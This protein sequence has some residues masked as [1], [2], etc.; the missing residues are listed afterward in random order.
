MVKA[1]QQRQGHRL[2]HRTQE[3]NELAV[4]QP[5]PV[6]DP[7]RFVRHAVAGRRHFAVCDSVM[8]MA[9]ETNEG[10]PQVPG[11]PCQE[12]RHRPP[13]SVC[14][15][16]RD[17]SLSHIVAQ[18]QR[19]SP[20]R[21][22][23]AS[24]RNMCPT[25]PATPTSTSTFRS[26]P[27]R[28]RPLLSGCEWFLDFG[29]GF[30]ASAAGR[31]QGSPAKAPATVRRNRTR[32]CRGSRRTQVGHPL[33]LPGQPAHAEPVPRWPVHPGLLRRRR[34]VGGHR[35]N[36][37]VEAMNGNGDDGHRAVVSSACH[38]AWR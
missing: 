13:P 27:D 25:P 32:P 38:A 33:H 14:R 11:P 7:G 30:C 2:E 21:P 37:W 8:R 24:S 17:R 36:D 18:P 6:K 12:D 20:R 10:G 23:P 35:D 19:S 26:A 1:G 4:L 28:P 3:Y 31:H 34:Q 9:P 15:A 5:A 29:E 22:G 16:V